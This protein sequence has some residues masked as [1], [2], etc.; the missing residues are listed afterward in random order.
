MSD[1]VKM[2]YLIKRRQGV[3]RDELAMHWFANHI[4][5]VIANMNSARDSGREHAKKY[6]ATLFSGVH[7]GAGDWDGIANLWWDNPLPEPEA[8][9]G[10]PPRDTFQQKVKPYR[11]W[12]TREFLALDGELPVDPL[13]LNDPFPCTR[14]GFTKLNVLVR[15]KPGVDFEKMFTHWVEVHA[16]N[17]SG[18][19]KDYGCFRYVLSLSVSPDTEEFAGLGEIYFEGDNGLERFQEFRDAGVV[20]PDGFEEYTDAD[21]MQIYVADTEMVGIP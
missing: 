16:P 10:D 9:L 11:P 15:A 5:G 1:P 19:L 7:A 8:M 17:A 2:I 13:T 18:P 20:E 14:S 4:P 3:S 21:N 12:A 6:I